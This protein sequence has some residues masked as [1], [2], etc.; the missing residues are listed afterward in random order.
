MK[1]FKV[2]NYDGSEC[3]GK[4]IEGTNSKIRFIASRRVAH[5]DVDEN[6]N[7]PDDTVLNYQNGKFTSRKRQFLLT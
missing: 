3:K 6:D 2:L 4:I 1:Q 7:L 5:V